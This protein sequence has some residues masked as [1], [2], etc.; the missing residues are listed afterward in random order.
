[1][2]INSNSNQYG[3]MS[4]G[5]MLPRARRNM[6]KSF[7]T[8]SLALLTGY[9]LWQLMKPQSENVTGRS[10]KPWRV[11]LLGKTG[12]SREYEVY[13][14]A[15]SWGPHAELSVLRYSQ[16]GSDMSSRKVTAV[17]TP[18]PVEITTGAMSDFVGLPATSNILSLGTSG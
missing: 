14:P 5:V 3:R 12:D 6:T 11:K 15:G 4:R 9:G 18:V 7:I 17:G 13:A 2:P 10:G 8:G 1:M 16:L